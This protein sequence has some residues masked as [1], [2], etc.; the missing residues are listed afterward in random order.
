MDTVEAYLDKETKAMFEKAYMN[1]NGR[2]DMEGL[3]L[4]IATWSKPQ[5]GTGMADWGT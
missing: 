1:R 5:E 3:K 2:W 4:D